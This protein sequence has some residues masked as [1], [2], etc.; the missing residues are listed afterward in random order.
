[1][2]GLETTEPQLGR[3]N[4]ANTSSRSMKN[5]FS[6]SNNIG[7]ASEAVQKKQKED[8]VG[9]L[10]NMEMNR[11]KNKIIWKKI[12]LRRWLNNLSYSF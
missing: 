6:V 11:S 5:F 10:D 1:M 12:P 8:L 7:D 2:S 9:E 3:L 4:L